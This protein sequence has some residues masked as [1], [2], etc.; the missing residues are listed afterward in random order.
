MIIHQIT[1]M[2]ILAKSDNKLWEVLK[3]RIKDPFQISIE[4]MKN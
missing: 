1:Q 3:H 4:A 2:N